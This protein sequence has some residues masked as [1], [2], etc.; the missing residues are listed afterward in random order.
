M[1][2]FF[3]RLRLAGSAVVLAFGIGAAPVHAENFTTAREVRPILTATRASWVSLR[4]YNG[5]DLLY[6]TQLAAWRCGLSEVRFSVN[7]G[8]EQRW[9]LEP[10]YEGEA[11]PNAIKSQD[12]W[13]YGQAA[14]GSVETVKVRIL[15]DDGSQDLMNYSRASILR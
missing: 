13:V 9:A 11:S 10:C 1:T 14:L 7:G 3:N 2:V 15:Y 12:I 8:S 4:E 5:K 6:F